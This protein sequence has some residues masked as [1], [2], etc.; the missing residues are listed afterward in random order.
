MGVEE[1]ATALRA[2]KGRQGPGLPPHYPTCFGC[3]PEAEAG[4]HLV[5]QLDGSE[6]VASYTFSE[7]HS[8]APGIA[9]GG[10]VAALAD[11]VLGYLLIVAREPGV[12]RR[13]ESTTC[14]RFSSEC[15][16]TFVLGSTDAR[17]ASC[18]CRA[19]GPRRKAR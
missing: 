19:R 5:A 11:D 17:G 16:T 15:R 10:T 13:L 1:Y 8:G 2:G 14:S 7:R 9:H 18:L 6:V 12:T 3:G 4:L